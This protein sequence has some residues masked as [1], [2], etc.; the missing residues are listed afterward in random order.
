[1]GRLL[2]GKP[3]FVDNVFSLYFSRKSVNFKGEIV[4][5]L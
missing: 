4:K 5:V 3:T 2:S 1:M